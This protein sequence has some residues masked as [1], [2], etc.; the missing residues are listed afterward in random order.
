MTKKRNLYDAINILD[1]NRDAHSCRREDD[2]EFEMSEREANS[3]Q[4]AI[5]ILY[6]IQWKHDAA[7]E[8]ANE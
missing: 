7:L 8:A 4:D 5:D 3:C 2:P 6:R 1:I